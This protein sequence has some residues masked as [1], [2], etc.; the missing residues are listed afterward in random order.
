MSTPRPSHPPLGRTAMRPS[1]ATLPE[2][3]RRAIAD[4]LGAPVAS[5]RDQGGG[6]TPGVAARLLLEDGARAF[7][8]AM[9]LAHPLAAAYR[10]E[11]RVA[12]A[13][14]AAS[15]APR[16]HWHGTVTGWM[17]LVLADIDGRHPDLSPGSPDIPRVV[18]AITA[19]TR[20]LT[21]SPVADLEPSSTARGSWLHGWQI[22]VQDAPADPDAE[23]GV[24]ERC[25]L[26]ELA[27]AEAVW[28]AHAD[29]PAL[30]HGDIRPDNLLATPTGGVAVVDW[31]HASR[32]AAWQDLADLVPHLIMAGHDPA[33]AEH[34]LTGLPA[35][36]K[37]DA[38]VLTSYAA[39]Y[40][41]YW[42]RMSRRPA[43]D[44]VPH[45]RPYQ[46]RAA[47][48]ALAWVRH[49]TRGT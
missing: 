1:W 9:P 27:R 20:A 16:L 23:L 36:D 3:V 24:W 11:G 22:L 4:R 45:L 2:K 47:A 48:A 26:A 30:V 5:A 8:K 46:R 10:H 43:P 40:A 35:W 42:M 13:L 49:R 17:V 25:H 38:E 19:M 39:A 31:A 37:T 12:D 29:G 44:G 18:R 33:A 32:G 14:P 41:G 28:P 21:P 34:R 15:P 7:V 6:F